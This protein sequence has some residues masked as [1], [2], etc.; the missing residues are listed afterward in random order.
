[1]EQDVHLI[2]KLQHNSLGKFTFPYTL[3][4]QKTKLSLTHGKLHGS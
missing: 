3:A 4:L 2:L 1:M